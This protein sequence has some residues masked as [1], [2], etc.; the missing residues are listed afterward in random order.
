VTVCDTSVLVA[1]FATWHQRHDSALAAVGRTTGLIGHV[2]FETLSVLTRM[3]EPFR[4]DGA[5]V[6][7][8]LESWYPGRPLTLTPMHAKR[9]LSGLVS[10]GVNG[11]AVY[12]GLVAKTAAAHDRHL[13]S[14]DTRA[15][16]TYVKLGVEF[17]IID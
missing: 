14:L 2:A 10:A 11:G 6:L 7:E 4:A 16:L 9:V 5:T 17:S 1:A 8:F 15:R 13:L 3:P 12:D